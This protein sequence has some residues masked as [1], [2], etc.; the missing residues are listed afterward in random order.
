MKAGPRVALVL[1]VV[2]VLSMVAPPVLATQPEGIEDETFTTNGVEVWEDSI[3][4]LRHDFEDAQT[5][6]ETGN[7]RAGLG[8]GPDAPDTSLNRNNIGIR[9]AGESV[10]LRFTNRTALSSKDIADSE[11]QL[12]AAKVTGSGEPVTTFSEAVDLISQ[13]NAN[14]NATFENVPIEN[15]SLQGGETTFEHTGNAGHYVYFLVDT[16]DG[17]F[18]VDS[19]VISKEDTPRIIGV[20]QITFQRDSPTSVNAP[21][22]ASPGEDM[23][24]EIDTSEEFSS[25]EGSVTHTVLVYDRSK[26]T[27]FGQGY[28]SVQVKDR[29]RIDSD[30]NLSEDAELLHEIDEVNGEANVEE[31]IEVNGIDISDGQVSRAIS[32][33]Q[34][35]DFVAEDLDANEPSNTINVDETGEDV[36]LDASVTALAE[37]DRDETINVR[38]GSDDGP[39][40]ETG[41]Y[42][43]VYIGALDDNSSAVTTSTGT[44][45]IREGISV[46]S[47]GTSKVSD[48]GTA[49]VIPRLDDESTDPVI[50]SVDFNGLRGGTQARVER[51]ENPG[52][53]ISEPDT[54][55]IKTYLQ[56]DAETDDEATVDITVENTFDDVNNAQVFKY[57]E[58]EGEF[59]ALSTE[60]VG[61]VGDTVTLRFVT[62][63]STFAIGE[64]TS[65]TTTSPS[66]GTSS[67]SGGGGGGGASIPEGFTVS[68]LTPAD[69]EVTQGD[70]I[71]VSA[72]VS[73]GSYLDETQTIELRIGNETVATQELTLSNRES[74]TVEFTG[75]DT[76]NLE[77]EY[78]HEV[79]TDDDSQSGTLT[80]TA[81][82]AEG[83]TGQQ[84]PEQEEGTAQ[85]ADGEEEMETAGEAEEETQDGTP[86]FGPLVAVIA[87]IAA[88]LI[89]RRHQDR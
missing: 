89:A 83:D 86:G 13:E 30:F 88:A 22:T 27:D 78:E 37:R 64:N 38:A 40:W 63:F 32:L 16:D 4:T 75:V 36:R 25:D 19:G 74:A 41:E 56:I 59:R 70:V 34:V 48:D 42:R 67:S 85:E 2:L 11:V 84:D 35:V 8:S 52:S 15:T 57:D 17:R 53:S 69:V 73:T 68:D 33:G 14:D 87:L 23:Q 28:F 79:I 51:L 72:T 44:I 47:G 55:E 6:V 7:I 54:D 46:A 9:N 29:S 58:D 10:T 60:P 49:N 61:D 50:S 43:Y 62:D 26:F 45:S 76:S 31:G 80:V 77:G 5:S 24:F 81:A 39:D 20:E 21:A 82:G 18:G 1:S 66:S 71:D 3:F 65:T 12:I